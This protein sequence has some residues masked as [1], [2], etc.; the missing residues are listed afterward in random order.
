MLPGRERPRVVSIIGPGRS[1]STILGSILGELPGFFDAGEVRWL[2]ERGLLGNQP[3]GCGHGLRE[4]AV[5]NSAMVKLG[6]M[7]SPFDVVH[8]QHRVAALRHQWSTIQGADPSRPANASVT[9][10]TRTLTA[11]LT[12]V[13]D[14]TGAD[15]IIDSSER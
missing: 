12:S 10:Y 6:Q 5:W 9:R 13:A 4:C 8:D 14:V 2:W 7:P 15:T 3:C 1:G 11:L